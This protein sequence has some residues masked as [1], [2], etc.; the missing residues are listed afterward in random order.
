[1][2][3]LLRLL[4]RPGGGSLAQVEVG[5]RPLR[6]LLRGAAAGAL[7]RQRRRP[8]LL[9]WWHV[10]HRGRDQLGGCGGMPEIACSW[11]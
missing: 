11:L 7:L 3:V 4:R 6:L 1:M 8:L 2:L 10:Y 5:L 9:P